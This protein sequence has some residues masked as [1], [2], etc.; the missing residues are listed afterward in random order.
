MLQSLLNIA[1]I[2]G[3][4]AGVPSIMLSVRES[5]WQVAAADLMAI[6]WIAK[7]WHGKDMAYRQRTY[8]LFTLMYILAMVLLV[9]IDQSS[10]MYLMAIPVLAVLLLNMRVAAWILTINT[11]SF[12]FVGYL[13]HSDY[14]LVAFNGNRFL[15]WG[16]IAVN[17]FAIS[18][19]LTI[20][21]EFLILSFES[22]LQRQHEHARHLRAMLY[23]D[24]MT[25]LPTA[26][27]QHERINALIDAGTAFSL[28][29]LNLDGFR[30]VNNNLGAAGGNAIL[31]QV[32]K[33]MR[34]AVGGRGELARASG[35]EFT[36]IVSHTHEQAQLRALAKRVQTRLERPLPFQGAIVHVALSVGISRFPIDAYSTDEILRKAH[37]ALQD[38][39]AQGGR[40]ICSYESWMDAN[41]QEQVWLDHHLRDALEKNQFALYYQPKILLESGRATSVEGLLRWKHPQ[42]G[43]IP[44]DQ[45]IPRAEATGLIIPIGRW[46]LET[47]AR[48]AADWVAQGRP[49]RV[50]INVSIRQLADPELIHRLGEAQA[51]A[52]GLLDIEL[53]ESCLIANEKESLEFVKQCHAMG[54]GVHLDDFGT[55][56]SSLSRLGSMPLTVIKLDRAFISPIGKSQKSDALLKAMMS[57][58]KELRLRVVAEGVETQEQADYLQSLGVRYAQGWLY[59]RAMSGQDCD[60]WLEINL[61]GRTPE[62]VAA[63]TFVGLL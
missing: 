2:L 32:A 16:I 49:V 20:S 7:L 5:L 30:L 22:T 28:M 42:R 52:S 62:E 35:A 63:S 37:V 36:L 34:S 14:T 40:G 8:Q 57:I 25:G 18:V 48:Q 4:L 38:V 50:A 1:L 61:E 44:P 23:T 60:G 47:A 17:F 55:G 54:F 33:I 59:A 46:V 12:L 41:Q 56:Y 43:N 39:I 15:S 10:Q 51:L 45:F 27:A 58:G 6:L 21:C 53:T 3:V 24:S 26:N 9:Y 11:L 19:L 31:A 29:V 13:S